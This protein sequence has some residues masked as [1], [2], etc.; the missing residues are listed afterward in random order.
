MSRMGRQP[1]VFNEKVKVDFKD[2]LIS[3]TGP[4][5]NIDFKVPAGTDLKVE[6]DKVL[7]EADLNTREGRMMAGTVRAII[8]NMVEGVTKGFTKKLVLN[9]VGYRAQLSGQKLTMSLGF[10]HPIEYT[11]DK[12][13][14][15]QVE[16][17]N[18]L[19][20]T[21]CDKQL[22]GQ[23]VAELRKFRPPE[24][25]KGKGILFEGEQIRRKAGKTAKGAK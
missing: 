7:V 15:G 24:P 22:L 10:S 20:L 5:G 19:T 14:K 2:R 17:N 9:G 23:T 1:V 25:Y 16:A 3:V 13:I 11:L 21:S 12:K 6:K 18:K 8:N 4:I